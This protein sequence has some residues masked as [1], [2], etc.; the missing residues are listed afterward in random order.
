MQGQSTGGSLRGV[1]RDATGARVRCVSA[2]AILHASSI[3]RGAVCDSRGEFR[4]DG[5]APGEYR[6]RIQAA[7]FATASAVISVRIGALREINVRMTPSTLRQSVGVVAQTSSITS[8]PLNTDS[9]VH[10]SVITSRDLQT[11]PLSERSFANVAYLAPG[12]EPVEPS[13]PTKARITAVSTGGSSGLNNELSVDGGDDSDDFIGGFLQNYSPDA[14]REFSVRTAQEDAKTGGT[15]A[16]SIVIVTKSGTNDWHGDAAIYERAAALNARFPIEN[17]APN[18]KQPFSRQNYIAT[19]GGPVKKNRLWFF[20]SYEQV[21][22]NASIAYSTVSTTQFD[23]LRTLISEGLVPGVGEI[24][25]PP[26]VPIPFRDYLGLLRLDFD[27]SPRS[28]WVLRGAVDNYTTHN[29]LVQQA[30]LP[31]TGLLTHNNYLDLV[32][33]NQYQFSSSWLADFVFSAGGL[34]LT[35]TRNSNLGFA[36]AFPFSSTSLTVSGFE[37]YGDNQFATP[38]TFFPSERSQEK[39]QGRYDVTKTRTD[40]TVAFGINFM[41]E[42]VLDGA[43]PSN[44]ETLYQFPQDPA[45][46]LN[47]PAQFIADKVAGARTTNL[48][49]AFAQNVQRL[50]LYAQDSWRVTPRT[51]LNYGLRY[52]TTFG[53]FTAAG[54]SQMENPGIAPC[55]RSTYR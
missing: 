26:N 41:H 38:I 24:Q 5:L 37:T 1:V 52:S 23:A 15:T 29:N 20:A 46:Y 12:T 40:H 51:V 30:T 31:S 18:P 3:T 50:A 55:R 39:Y 14:I 53:L 22:E 36:L 33:S 21:H 16:G 32:L 28:D 48:G 27:Q 35:Q 7:G 42:P 10:Q 2:K 4:M 19:L 47:K 49:G 8:Q 43:F 45:Y 9:A 25:V 54:R 17:P 11:L 13:D 44:T 34:H 6:L